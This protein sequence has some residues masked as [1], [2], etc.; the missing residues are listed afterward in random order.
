[1]GAVRGRLILASFGFL[2]MGCSEARKPAPSEAT[3]S[4]GRTTNAAPARLLV[5]LIRLIA[6][7]HQ[8]EGRDVGVMGYC[9]AEPEGNALYVHEEDQRYFFTMNSVTLDFEH[10]RSSAGSCRGRHVLVL[11]RFSAN[12]GDSV[13]G[14]IVV[15]TVHVQ[16]PVPREGGIE[17]P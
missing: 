9:W 13:S 5:S 17:P 11:G 3:D 12:A 4:G 6:N 8:Y 16:E 1:M 2:V 15:D 14:S 7:P 10:A